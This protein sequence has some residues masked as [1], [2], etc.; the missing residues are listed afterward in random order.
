MTSASS[1]VRVSPRPWPVRLGKRLRPWFNARIARD[2]LVPNAPVLDS[3]LFTWTLGL[4]TAWPLIREE[5]E[6]LLLRRDEIPP[7]HEISPD[8]ARIAGDGQWRSFFLYGYGYR[9]DAN[10][11]RAPRTAALLTG[12]PGLNSA[13]FSILGPGARIPR[14]RGVTKGILTCHLGLMVPTAQGQCRMRV[15]DCVVEWREGRCLVFDDSQMHE[16]WNETDQT[17][18]VLL[19]QFER[20]TRGLGRWMARLF[21]AAVRRTAFIQEARRNL[22][23][24]ESA[25]KR[26]EAL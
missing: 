14:H 11:D 1:I 15:D 3:E 26:S 8:H 19:I 17:R 18:V 25:I 22:S 9:V 16:V 10:C 21:L 23:A 20:P 6:A 5:A 24:W 12:V 4:E 2:S 7:L 13:F